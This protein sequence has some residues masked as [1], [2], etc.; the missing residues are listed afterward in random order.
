VR[1]IAGTNRDLA[2]EVDL[3][4]FRQDLLYRLRVVEVVVPPLRERL[5]DIEAL[6]EHFLAVSA[7]RVGRLPKRLAPDALGA[8]L[9]YGWPGNVRELEHTLEAAQVYAEGEEIHAPD[10]P[11][12]DQLFLQRGRRA[13]AAPRA[14]GSEGGGAP[15]AG[16]REALEGIERER[17]EQAL[18]QHSGNK[19][20]TAQ[21]LGISRGALLRRLKRYGL[22]V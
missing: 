9:E 6:A 4:V 13:T 1:V 8:L 10:L 21:A 22:M 15:R 3:G 12:F 18:A 7:D 17:L 11:I 20:Q 5:G 14:V 2:K 19:T 16:L